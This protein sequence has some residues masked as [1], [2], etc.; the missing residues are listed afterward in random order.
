VELGVGQSLGWARNISAKSLAKAITLLLKDFNLRAKISKDARQVV[1]G[2]GTQRILNTLKAKERITQVI[3]STGSQRERHNFEVVFLGG[4]QAGC[5]GLLTLLASGCTV[6]GIVAYDSTIEQLAT[7][8]RL[9]TF[10]SIKQPEVEVLLSKCDLLVS[11]HGKEIVPG[12]LL[13]LPRFR[14]INAH[15]CLYA[16]KGADPV[17]RLLRDGNTKASVGVHRMTER[18]DEGEVLV[19][20]FV[21]VTG[22]CSVEEIYN[23]LYPFYAL[24]LLKAL[25]TLDTSQ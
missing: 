6:S 3:P 7:L 14:G 18:V 5:I 19:E 4:A 15:P 21:D 9:P 17:G 20:E 25:R 13:E 8:L 24:V 1:D 23:A 11:V 12:R 22:K 10:S 2:R 16:Y